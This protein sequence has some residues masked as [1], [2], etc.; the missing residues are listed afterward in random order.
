MPTSASMG[1]TRMTTTITSP[2]FPLSHSPAY[3]APAACNPPT[4]AD[5]VCATPSSCPAVK[6]S[7]HRLRQ[8]WQLFS[9]APTGGEG[10]AAGHR[11]RPLQRAN[12]LHK[13]PR[14]LRILLLQILQVRGQ[15]LLQ[16]LQRHRV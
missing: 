13:L 12:R 10:R 9:L 6:S 2:P 14:R 3:A 5:S 11:L 1:T 16:P 4:A 8:L 15:M 7:S